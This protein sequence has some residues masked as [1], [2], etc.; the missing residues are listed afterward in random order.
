MGG[1]GSGAGGMGQAE[2]T[3]LRQPCPRPTR[4][5]SQL[6]EHSELTKSYFARKHSLFSVSL[7]TYCYYLQSFAIAW[8]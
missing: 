2:A 1:Q 3:A 7:M 4:A 5:E 6:S 8:S